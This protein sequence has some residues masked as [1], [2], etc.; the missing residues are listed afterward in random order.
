MLSDEKI[1]HRWSEATG[2]FLN[3]SRINE[4]RK[5]IRL[6][7]DVQANRQWQFE[8]SADREADGKP[9]T[10]INLV[11][12]MIK[13]ISGNQIMNRINIEYVPRVDQFS[14][15]AQEADIIDDAVDKIEDTS[16]F[17]VADGQSDEDVLTCGL[18]G[19]R[20]YFDY[21][22]PKAPWG[23][24]KTDRIFPG[25]L[26]YDHTVRNR[27]PNE[28]GRYAAVV[29]P[30][31]SEWLSTYMEEHLGEGSYEVPSS[32][33]GYS[34]RSEF[35]D[36]FNE[37]DFNDVD[38]LYFF[39]WYEMEDIYDVFNPFK[40][41]TDSFQ[42]PF[43][44]E[45][46]D[47]QAAI[48]DT[49][50]SVTQDIQLD[51][52]QSLLSVNK[53]GYGKLREAMQLIYKFLGE[54]YQPIKSNKRKGKFYYRAEIARGRVIKKSANWSQTGF[55]INFKTGY[56]D[57]IKNI[58]FGVLRYMMPV[59]EN[60][61]RAV[62][63]YI[64]YLES[65]PKGGMY[66]ELGA[67]P[68]KR[69]FEASR[70]QSKRVTLVN[71]DALTQGRIQQKEIP[72]A[73]GG[74]VDFIRLMTEMLPRTVGLNQEYFGSLTSGRIDNALF[75]RLYKQGSA[76]MA[77]FF[78]SK[79]EYLRRQGQLWVEAAKLWAENNDGQLLMRISPGKDQERYFRLTLDNLADEYDIAA[80]ERTETAEERQENFNK[81]LEL[82]GRMN[83]IDIMPIAMKYAPFEEDDKDAIMQLMQP[84]P[85]PQPDPIQQ[86]LIEANVN[87]TNA[88]AA[89]ANA[90]AQAKQINT[91]IKA[92]EVDLVDEKTEAQIKEIESSAI[93][94]MAKAGK[95]MQSGNAV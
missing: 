28:K 32:S 63:D 69:S 24:P 79:K 41:I 55:S 56:Y 33:N 22:N 18:A 68:E 38:M 54:E 76:V 91:A 75:G 45:Q 31:S 4:F 34:G 26:L 52:R 37:D 89:E 40:E 62:S 23:E 87:L 73:P 3:S 20:T 13:Q 81:L 59:Q 16:G 93:L 86:A 49:I 1:L 58:Y 11:S 36:F 88:Q 7:Y 71:K 17:K 5:Q 90:D 35:L 43:N 84:P 39:E 12:P 9:V 64:E 60:L 15:F 29:E 47:I 57:E 92:K 50:G 30:V 44:E 78:L 94:N 8:E 27:S 2:S 42:E 85:P 61:N 74:L 82:Q 21:T 48:F 14:D 53:K 46:A 19:T 83:N 67:I 51:L 95:E 10:V 72:V 80:V 6:H 25:F 65:V 77:N 70:A 66:A